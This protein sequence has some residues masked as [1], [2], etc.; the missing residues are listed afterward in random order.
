M[1]DF[2]LTI[3]LSSHCTDAI[4]ITRISDKHSTQYFA[5]QYCYTQRQRPDPS[6]CANAERAGEQQM[7]MP[8]VEGWKLPMTHF[9]SL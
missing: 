3:S 7:P 1:A 9:P 8:T 6:S 5:G 2:D 4:N